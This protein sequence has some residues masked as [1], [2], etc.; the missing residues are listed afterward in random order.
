MYRSL[1]VLSAIFFSLHLSAQVLPREGS[2]LNYRL[3][4][5]SF[6]EMT[7]ASSYKIEIAAGTFTNH[8]SFKRKIVK[9]VESK[10]SKVIAE[11]PAFGSQYTWRIVYVN[12][13]VNPSNSPL[14]HFSTLVNSH[15]DSTKLRLRILQPAIANKDYYVAVDGGGVLYDMKGKPVWFVPDTNG[16][17]G[18][19]TDLKFTPQGTITFIYRNAFEINYNGEVLWKAPDNGTVNGETGRSELYHH[20]FTKLASGNFMVLGMKFALC[21][22]VTGKDSSYLVISNDN[23][24][25]EKDGFKLGRF[26]NLIE[27]DEKGNVIWTWKSSKYLIET[28]FAYF[29]PDDSNVRFDAHA[30]AFFFDEKNKVIYIGFR[31]LNRIIKIEYPGG[32]VLQTYGEAFKPGMKATGRGLFCGQHNVG[33]ANDGYLYY[34]NNNSCRTD[35]LPTI[36]M[37]KEPLSPSDTIKKVWEY[38]CTADPKYMNNYRQGGNAVELPGLSLFVNMGSQYSKLFIVD[39]DKKILWS[40][41]P[42]NYVEGEAKWMPMHE[43]RATII[44]R[45]DLE[46]LI[47]NTESTR[48]PR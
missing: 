15:V 2:R 12:N 16:F 28:D 22:S 7:T 39:R 41:L 10:G 19:V 18:N 36:V 38:T 4:G 23:D 37:L 25:T 47:W 6:P 43:Y 29:N 1:I 24:K 8:E 46:K 30:N 42:E 44:S 17:G 14:Y 3:I 27:Y 13:K 5:F 26:D 34:F 45:K 31:N 48:T 35:A 20:E 40:A 32:K 21:K 9:S 11:V 33:C